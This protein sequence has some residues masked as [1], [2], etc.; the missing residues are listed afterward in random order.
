MKVPLRER[1]FNPRGPKLLID[2]RVKLIDDSQT[3]RHVTH[4]DKTTE[5]EVQTRV[6]E[7]LKRRHRN[8][9][10]HDL[11]MSVGD[12]HQDCF[13]SGCIGAVR[14]T[15]LHDN[16]AYLVGQR[17]VEHAAS[18]E[19]LVGYDEVFTVPIGDRGSPNSHTRYC[20]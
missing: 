5:T 8:R 17:P 13:G 9:L 14:N 4:G 6:A 16:P 18:D 10:R 19:V 11:W 15:H 1:D 20:T 12:R 7:F 2:C 3:A